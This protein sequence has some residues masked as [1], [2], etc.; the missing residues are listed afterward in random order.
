MVPPVIAVGLT[1]HRYRTTALRRFG[2]TSKSCGNSRIMPLTMAGLRPTS[3]LGI[4]HRETK[5]S[6]A[7]A[8]AAA[9]EAAVAAASGGRRE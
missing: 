9:T 5:Q 6:A 4:E 1:F 7:A 3:P 8:A 2:R